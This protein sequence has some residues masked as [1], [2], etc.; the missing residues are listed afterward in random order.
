MCFGEDVLEI[1]LKGVGVAVPVAERIDVRGG[2]A[3][4]TCVVDGVGAHPVEPVVGLAVIFHAAVDLELE[5]VDDLPVEGRVGVPCGA[6]LLGIIVR[7]CDQ[8]LHGVS[9][10]FLVL[11][12]EELLPHGDGGVEDGMLEASVRGG[13]PGIVIQGVGSGA[14]DIGT[15][16]PDIDVDRCPVRGL[17]L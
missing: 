1:V 12:V 14:A 15:G 3:C 7:D 9:V 5:V 8:G 11:A 6:Y 2:G 4:G 16:V 10:V 13:L 17:E